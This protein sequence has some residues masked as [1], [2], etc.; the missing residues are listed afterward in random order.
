MSPCGS[1][2]GDRDPYKS[3]SSWCFS[4]FKGHFAT[5]QGHC[6]PLTVL[7]NHSR[8]NLMLTACSDT[9]TPCVRAHF[10]VIF[11]RYGLP[12]Q[13]NF[14][15]GASWGAPSA[16]GQ[17]TELGRWLVQLGIRVCYSRPHHPQTNGKDERFLRS[18]KAE[19]LNGVSF[20]SPA[21]VQRA[22]DRWRH[23]YNHERP[24]DALGLATP[25]SRYH[26]S[27]RL[28]TYPTVRCCGSAG[29]ASRAFAVRA[30]SSPVS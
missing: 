12:V 2:F 24:H 6:S 9:P 10:E 13:I 4:T 23:S 3:V 1:V 11:R 27:P 17:I 28:N 18:L 8:F 26:I 29:A 21:Q 16:P 19:V 14:D 15:N 5:A 25:V 20:A 22:L 30:T 7:D